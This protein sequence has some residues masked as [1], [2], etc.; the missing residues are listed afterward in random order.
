MTQSSLYFTAPCTVEI[1]DEPRATLPADRLRVQTIVS[2]I[3]AGTEMLF[4]RSQVPAELSTDATI[5]ALS[6]GIAYPL[7]Y[8]YACVGR[9]VEAGAQVP[10][11]ASWIDRTVFAFNPHETHFCALP[12]ALIPVPDGIAPEQAAL[13]PN[14][15]TAVNFTID[16]QPII[17]ERVAVIGQGIVGLLT[18]HLLA[19]SPLAE[20]NALDRIPQRLAQAQKLGATHRVDP[21]NESALP[22]NMDLIYELSGNP[23]A[24]DT[25][26]TLCG[27]DA[28][29]IVGSWYGTKR[30][31]I[32]L[33]GHFHRNRIRII[34]SQVSTIAPATSGRWTKARRLDLAW[35][36]LRQL[37]TT[38]LITHRISF[39]Q[40]AD[41][42]TLLD[43]EPERVIQV[44]LNY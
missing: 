42:Y 24:L 22:R 2:A 19:R 23:A 31:E 1:R 39:H 8:G 41:A 13:L 20:L 17:G 21:A 10:D 38:A 30:A 5:E 7:K 28:R 34:S 12:T 36:M 16:G 18:T 26:I 25:A 29:V 4:Y 40:A 15:E 6:G 33:G 9:V 14:M 43:Q 3:S 44:I 32:D 37:D 27:F 35:S 11:G